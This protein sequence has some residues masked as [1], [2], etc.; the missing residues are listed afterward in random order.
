MTNLET[1]S[2]KQLKLIPN[3]LSAIFLVISLI[4]FL[5]AT[6]LTAKYFL[7]TPINCYL[8]GGCEKV[9]TS[10]YAT[11]YGIPIALLGSIYYLIIF[12]LVFIYF[13]TKN[14]RALKFAAWLTFIG[15]FVSLALLYLQFFVIKAI[16]TYCV[17]SAI[18]SILLFII[19]LIILNRTLEKNSERS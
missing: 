14:Q 15:L 5:N 1:L 2:N 3:W 13:D 10:Q 11:V 17:A 6:Y 16:C 8:S 19:G 18:D 7:K 9:T 4:G 12:V